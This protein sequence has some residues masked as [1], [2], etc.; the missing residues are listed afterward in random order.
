MVPLRLSLLWRLPLSLV[1]LGISSPS[2]NAGPFVLGTFVGANLGCRPQV[3]CPNFD[4]NQD[5][6]FGIAS[7]DN[8]AGY[9]SVSNLTDAFGDTAFT[10]FAQANASFGK[11]Q[12]GASGNYDLSSASTRFASAFAYATDQ[13]TLNG[14]GLAGTNGTLDL[15]F[16]LDGVLQGSGGGGGATFVAVGW[17]Q[18]PELFG[19]GNEQQIFQYATSGPYGPVPSAPIVVSPVSF[20]WGQ[21]FYLT[22]ALAVGAGTP[23][24][25]LI[26]CDGGDACATP[27][28]GSGSG[29]A[30]F[31]NTMVLTGL[32]PKDANGNLV[33]DAQFSS[34]SGTQYSLNG[35]EPVPEPGSL[36]LLGTGMAALACKRRRS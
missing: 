29:T 17:G 35:V 21:P 33:L 26:D 27:V 11:L 10:Y 22:I 15:S 12:A 36:L 6:D 4:G 31:Y 32:L 3:T 18:N 34:G 19:S 1:C 28:S 14:P 8:G 9:V 7:P 5:A 30:D 13:L 24:T 20:V 25:S 2:A 16:L 23:I